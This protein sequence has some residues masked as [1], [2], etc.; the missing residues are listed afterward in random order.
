MKLGV[1]FSGHT[2]LTYATQAL[3][4]L[5][6]VRFTRVIHKVL[7]FG[8]A[9]LDSSASHAACRAIS[10]EPV[11]AGT[12]RGGWTRGY[13]ISRAVQALVLGSRIRGARV[14]LEV[15]S[16]ISAVADASHAGC[17]P[18]SV[19]SSFASAARGG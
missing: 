3:V 17:R 8:C 6:R 7:V 5:G 1:V 14:I 15:L 19:E 16:T 4:V 18:I 10:V 2:S 11:F 13:A 12:A 9:T